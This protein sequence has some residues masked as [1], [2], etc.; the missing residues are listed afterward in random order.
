MAGRTGVEN[1]LRLRKGISP[2]DVAGRPDRSPGQA[3][4]KR[5]QKTAVPI[6]VPVSGRLGYLTTTD[7]WVHYFFLRIIMTQR[8][9]PRRIN[10]SE[11][12]RVCKDRSLV[13]G[14]LLPHGRNDNTDRC[15]C[16]YSR[17]RIIEY[18]VTVTGRW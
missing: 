14:R 2:P 8:K 6:E 18:G 7:T 5:A 3:S 13:P 9:G 16:H 10:S 1:T 15:E 17:E 4:G 12:H 11:G